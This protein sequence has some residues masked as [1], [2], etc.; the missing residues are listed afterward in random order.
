[1]IL[2]RNNKGRFL[3]GH[4]SIGG[5]KTR[6]NKGI[7]VIHNEITRKKIS[8][9]HKK[10]FKEHPEAILQRQQLAARL[11]KGKK[12][13]EI[14]GIERANK[15]KLIIKEART[16]QKFLGK[17]TSIEIKI[18]NFLRQ[19]SIEYFTHQYMREIEH[20]YQCDILVPSLNLVI[21][22]DGDYWHNYPFG[23]DIDHVRTKELEEKGFNV[24]RLWQNEIEIMDLISFKEKLIKVGWL[25][26]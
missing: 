8:D 19:L 22:C 24:L 4:K 11:S 1:M 23:N 2:E 5:F 14:Y 13:E 21:E 12:Y 25:K 15:I 7:K 18:Q 20:G 6:F 17:D 10:R 26:R 3:K 16:K 9:S